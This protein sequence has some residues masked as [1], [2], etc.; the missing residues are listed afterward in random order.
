MEIID[1]SRLLLENN[2]FLIVTHIRP[3]GDTLGSG[4]ALCHAL[5]R[6]GKS[7]YMYRNDGVTENYAE[8]VEPYSAPPSFKPDFVITVDLAS[9]DLFP[10]GFN[11]EV[12]LSIDHHASNTGYAENA[13]IM[14]ER[15]SCGEI[16]MELVLEMC[17]DIETVEADLLYI[18]V[19]TDTGC[20][21]Y[22]N[23]TAETFYAAAR[24][25]EAGAN[26]KAINK[27]IFRTHT[28]ERI[29]LESILYTQMRQYLCGV[30]TVVTATLDVIK[31]CGA[32]EN[33]LEDLAALAG[34]VKGTKAGVTIRETEDG[35]A[36]IS[37][38]TGGEINASEVCSRFGGGGHNMAAGCVMNVSCEEAERLM[39]Q[40]IREVWEG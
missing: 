8:L 36:K 3:D 22:A 37:L 15:A 5:R 21:C 33:D 25:L 27:K 6:A 1:C 38:R 11:S 19:S 9:R 20:F 7:A 29:R 2:N 26:N 40:A 39:V 18:A 4:A 16:V 32:T 30:I 28:I 10:I 14:S 35:G 17:G 23:T 13:L 34:R 31:S 12:W 24:L